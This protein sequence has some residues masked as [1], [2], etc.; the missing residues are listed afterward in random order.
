MV[1]RLEL[2]VAVDNYLDGAAAGG[3]LHIGL[4]QFLLGFDHFGLKLLYLAQVK[5]THFSSVSEFSSTILAPMLRAASTRWL[6]LAGFSSDF[7]SLRHHYTGY[8]ISVAENFFELL[9]DEVEVFAVIYIASCGTR[10]RNLEQGY[11]L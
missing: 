4:S 7:C 6:L 1:D 5:L 2:L 3:H 11:P 10:G 9:L 8:R